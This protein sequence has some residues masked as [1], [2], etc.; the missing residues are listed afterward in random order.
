MQDYVT[1]TLMAR[2]PSTALGGVNAY[3]VAPWARSCISINSPLS[4]KAQ[5][6]IIDNSLLLGATGRLQLPLQTRIESFRTSGPGSEDRKRRA[7]Q[8]LGSTKTK[9]YPTGVQNAAEMTTEL[10][11]AAQAMVR[12]YSFEVDGRIP[13]EHPAHALGQ[14]LAQ[15]RG[16]LQ[17]VTQPWRSFYENSSPFD[18]Q[19]YGRQLLTR[20]EPDKDYRNTVTQT[21]AIE[22]NKLRDKWLVFHSNCSKE[23]QLNLHAFQP[24]IEGVVAAIGQAM[25]VWGEKRQRGW[26]GKAASNFH[27]VCGTLDS[28]NNMM[29]MLPEASEYVSVFTGALSTV[30]QVC[31]L[32]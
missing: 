24:T 4:A 28:H 32:P 11:R 15:D 21:V 2:Q 31:A 17:H 25:A 16:D 8:P 19:R 9:Y 13:S 20:I 23:D 10:H 7:L 26:R 12:M 5:F 27:K 1:S 6:D 30:I 14:L 29:R 18:S 3:R 22:A